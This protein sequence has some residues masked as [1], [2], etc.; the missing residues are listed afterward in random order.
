M[1]KFN[2]LIAF[3]NIIRNLKYTIINIVGLAIGLTCF[4]F[5]A[6]YISDELKYDKFHAKSDRIYRVNRFYNS[7][8]V[9]EDAATCSFPC[10]P[11]LQFDYPDMVEEVV[12]F[13]NGFARQVFIE[14]RKTEEDVVRFNETGFYLVD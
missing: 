14:Y 4:L 10:G 13:Y 1:L 6:L 3:R 9:Q 5:I 11:T 2:F 12:R 8:N 7:N